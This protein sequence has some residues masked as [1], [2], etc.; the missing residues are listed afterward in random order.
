MQ[1]FNDQRRKLLRFAWNFY[2]TLFLV[3]K[4]INKKKVFARIFFHQWLQGFKN[5]TLVI[6]LFL[7]VDFFFKKLKTFWAESPLYLEIESVHMCT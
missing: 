5:I 6:F 2:Q 4:K 7:T 1:L 3:I